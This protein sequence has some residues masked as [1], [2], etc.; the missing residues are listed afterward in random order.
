MRGS[1]HL[2]LAAALASAAPAAAQGIEV[3]LELVL[4]VDISGSMDHREHTAQRQGYVSAFRH[5]EVLQAI[6]EGLT[7]RIAVSYVEWAGSVQAVVVPWTVIDGP[8][9]AAAFAARLEEAP[10]NEFSGTSISG[11]LDF[12]SQRFDE[13]GV[14]G[15]RR[16]IDVSGDGPNNRGR[17]VL[18]ARADAIARGIT[19]NGLPIVLGHAGGSLST[20]LLDIYYEDCVIGGPGAFMIAV[21]D[22]DR[23]PEAIRRKLVLEIVGIEPRIMPADFEVR[24]PRIDCLIG[25]RLRGRWYLDP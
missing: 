11:G 6:R 20:D 18:D 21:D 1:T 14:L 23:L 2:A 15:L 19:I 9:S 22:I 4:A 24:E 13:S 12:A 3:D 10:I 5:P 16:V 7:G 25:E 17:P 8:G